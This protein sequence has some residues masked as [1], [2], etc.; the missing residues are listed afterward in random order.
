MKPNLADA[1][2]SSRR[3]LLGQSLGLDAEANGLRRRP[4]RDCW[5]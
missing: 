5:A 1:S 4:E 2:S 3:S